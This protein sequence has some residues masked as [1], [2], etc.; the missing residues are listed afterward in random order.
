MQ[1]AVVGVM[2]VS[3]VGK[4][5]TLNE[6]KER[7]PI[8]PLYSFVEYFD[9]PPSGGCFFVITQTCVAVRASEPL[10]EG[11]SGPPALCSLVGYLMNYVRGSV[12]GPANEHLIKALEDIPRCDANEAALVVCQENGA[13]TGRE[14]TY[15]S[16]SFDESTEFWMW[17]LQSMNT[18]LT[19][20]NRKLD[21]V[22]DR[23]QT[24]LKLLNKIGP[25]D[26][27]LEVLTQNTGE[28]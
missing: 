3:S 13:L 9:T 12:S 24:A 19:S 27:K 1:I 14:P 28:I 22:V 15:S 25:G 5:Y 2:E 10:E 23:R 17:K 26:P 21:I 18:Y 20:F 8:F 16:D 4:S 6:G 11:T 7:Q